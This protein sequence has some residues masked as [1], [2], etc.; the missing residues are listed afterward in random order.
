MLFSYLSEEEKVVTLDQ[1]GFKDSYASGKI[2]DETLVFDN[3]VKTKDQF[4]TQWLLPLKDSWHRR[5][6]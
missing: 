6:V 4:L 2:N 5:F 3:L 1:H